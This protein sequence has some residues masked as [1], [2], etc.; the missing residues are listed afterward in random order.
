MNTQHDAEER[1]WDY[2]DGRCNATEKKS[3]EKMLES[4]LQWKEKY[5][6]LL[7]VNRLLHSSG[8]Q[9]PSMRFTKNVMEEIA[10]YQVAPATKTYI[11]K[12]IIRGIGIFFA[13]LII[14]FLVYG[15]SQVDWS[16]S[17][18]ATSQYIDLSKVDFSKFF[19]N[20][21]INVFMMLNA[22]LGLMLLD[23]YLASK[24]KKL[25]KEM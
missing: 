21:F 7:E 24:R 15:F 18:G 6:E 13:T 25:R 19:N 1:L 17:N 2:I 9:E 12:Y 5:G 4:N 20:T 16:A 22:V 8:L 10:K 23:R 11:N 3:I 14:G